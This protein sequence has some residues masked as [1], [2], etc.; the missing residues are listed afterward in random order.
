MPAE[1]HAKE[2]GRNPT[3]WASVVRHEPATVIQLGV[4]TRS[5]GTDCRYLCMQRSCAFSNTGRAIF[6]L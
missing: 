3:K 6:V 2:L 5:E 1:V 4:T